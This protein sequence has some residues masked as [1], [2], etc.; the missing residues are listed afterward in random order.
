MANG[1]YEFNSRIFKL[2]WPIL[3]TISVGLGAWALTVA[4]SHES[5]IST[6]ES[7]DISG[8]SSRI[9]QNELKLERVPPA[10]LLDRVIRLEVQVEGMSQILRRIDRKIP[11]TTSKN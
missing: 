1:D 6:L 2:I 9:N 4:I 7:Q 11:D 5:R 10:T 8:M 3:V